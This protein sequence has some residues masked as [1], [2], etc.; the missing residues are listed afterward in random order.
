MQVT[1]AMLVDIDLGKVT[2]SDDAKIKALNSCQSVPF[3]EIANMRRAV[4]LVRKAAAPK[5]A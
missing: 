3:N 2:K 4:P 5:S 1:G